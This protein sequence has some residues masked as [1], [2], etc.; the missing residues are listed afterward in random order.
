MAYRESIISE[1]P[2]SFWPLDDDSSLGVIKEATGKGTDGSYAGSIFDKSI[3]LVANGKYGTRLL[4]STSRLQLLSLLLY[5]SY[6][7]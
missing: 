1:S 5:L 6:L 4:N 3:P 2:I 7:P